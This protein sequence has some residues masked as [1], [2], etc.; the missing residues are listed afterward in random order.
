MGLIAR[1]AEAAGIPTLCMGS[2]LDILKTVNPPR[3]AF[4]DFPL[5]HTTGKPHDPEL[6]RDILMQALNSFITMTMP[7]SVNMLNFR[8]SELDEW[9]ETAQRDGD[10]RTIRHGTPQ[11]Q[12]DEDRIRAEGG[13]TGQ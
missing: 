9:K 7:G 6:Q 2:A 12:T 5:G 4:L 13:M 8:W 3:A 11:Y 10:S 1:Y